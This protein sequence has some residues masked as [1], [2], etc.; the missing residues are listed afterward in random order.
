MDAAVPRSPRLQ[1][2]DDFRDRRDD[3]VHH[4]G[5]GERHALVAHDLQHGRHRRAFVNHAIAALASA[6]HADGTLRDHGKQV[7]MAD[8]AEQP[9]RFIGARRQGVEYG[10]IKQGLRLLG[11]R[12]GVGGDERARVFG[13]RLVERNAVTLRQPIRRL[14][15]RPT[16][17][18]R[19]GLPQWHP[20]LGNGVR[21]WP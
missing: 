14:G 9:D 2:L 3:V 19:A 4:R 11:I 8:L 12:G 17:G 18:N 13:Q 16:G 6:F 5:L 1:R 10:G 20:G 21:L 15:Q 7:R